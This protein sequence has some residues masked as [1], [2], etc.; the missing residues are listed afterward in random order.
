MLVILFG[1]LYDSLPLIPLAIGFVWTLRYQKV[2]DLSLAG[3]FSV[4]SA[5]SAYLIESGGGIFISLIGGILVGVLVGLAMG[6]TVNI[7]RIDPLLSGL[8]IL[9]ISYAISLGITEG[10]IRIKSS[11]YPQS[12]AWIMKSEWGLPAW[13][14]PGAN[15]IFF[16]LAA[17][18]VLWTTAL[19]ATEW[20]CAFRALEDLTGGRSFLRSLGISSIRLS[21]IGF[22]IAGTLASISGILVALRDEQTTSSLGLDSLI[23]II[24]AYLLGLALFERRPTLKKLQGHLTVKR[25]GLKF[26]GKFIGKLVLRLA[27][28]VKSLPP[29]PAAALGVVAYFLVVNLVQRWAEVHWLPRV[30]MGLILLAIL[31]TR[32]AREAWRQ[33][34]RQIRST[35]LTEPTNPLEIKDLFVSYPTVIGPKPILRE[36]NLTAS[37]GEIVLLKG[38][39]GCGKTTLLRALADRIDCTGKF[40]IPV[41]DGLTTHAQ[42]T[43]AVAYVPQD[44]TESTAA[45]LSIAEHAVLAMRGSRLSLFRGWNRLA[46]TAF[47]KL[48][49]ADV[50]SDSTAPVQWLSGGQ[51]RRI[52]LGLL[53][54]RNPRPIIAALDEPFNDLDAAGRSHCSEI[55][56]TLA[57][58]GHLVILVDH[59]E[60]LSTTKIVD[61]VWIKEA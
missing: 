19:L 20:G 60:H 48:G 54:V 46:S 15:L 37:P 17:L 55:L 1:A 27:R 33:R 24:P 61:N 4:A 13:A 35:N 51:R 3:S 21:F 47:A 12:V 18:I 14:H 31:G 25:S 53:A 28:Y 5:C 16:T 52:L 58:N 39:N 10:T 34:K 56:T 40:S 7:L 45:T 42:R 32:P 26:I 9:F 50:S 11:H 30:F 41:G 59:Q 49:V 23:E 38:P 44:A 2:A 6:Y 22:V 8:V 36:V 43:C 57:N 29:A